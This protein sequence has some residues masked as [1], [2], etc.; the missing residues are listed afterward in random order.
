MNNRTLALL[1][2][3]ILAVVTIFGLQSQQSAVVVRPV[4]ADVA[5]GTYDR[6]HLSVAA[7]T[8]RNEQAARLCESEINMI[9]ARE[10]PEIE[11]RGN[12]VAEEVA[13][14]GS[15][16]TI[17]YRLAKEKLGWSSST[18]DY[19]EGEIRGRLQPAL[20]TCGRELDTALD[21]CELALRESTVMLATELAQMSPSRADQ[22]MNIAVDVRTGGDLDQALRNLG[23]SGGILTVSGAFD[24]VAIMNTTVFRTMIRTIVELAASLFATPAATAAGSAAVAAADGP[25]PVGDVIAVLGGAWTAYD[26]YAARREFEREI[27]ASLSNALPEM[28]RTVHH[29][30]MERLHSLQS[31]YQRAQD[32]IRNEMALN[33]TR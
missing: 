1:V 18:A 3:A 12:K 14:Y 32:R 6:I 19:V 5:A 30:L 11:R 25:L 7:A 2:A 31:E 33:L 21:R 17:I 4:P 29:Q 13:S 22:S 10:F 20:D 23:L 8:A 28:K 16:C 15:C 24:V 27:K 26:I 9:L